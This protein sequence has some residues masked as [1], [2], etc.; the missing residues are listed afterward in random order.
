MSDDRG[1]FAENSEQIA[2]DSNLEVGA[3]FIPAQSI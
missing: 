2:T 3:G 1:Q